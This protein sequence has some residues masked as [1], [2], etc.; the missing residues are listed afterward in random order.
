MFSPKKS[1]AAAAA[2]KKGEAETDD[3][4]DFPPFAYMQWILPDET[5]VMLLRR[6]S[7]IIGFCRMRR[8]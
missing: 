8:W 6:R 4:R 2:A 7:S 3:Q 5:V 1:A